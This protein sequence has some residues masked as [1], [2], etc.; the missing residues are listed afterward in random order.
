MQ[1]PLHDLVHSLNPTEKRYF[2]RFSELHSTEGSK[3]YLELFDLLNGQAEYD[4]VALRAGLGPKVND[5]QLAV[6]R[7]YL[8]NQILR[9]MRAYTADHSKRRQIRGLL[10]DGAFLYEKSLL[11]QALK[12]FGKAKALA[13]EMDDLL[14]LEEIGIWERRLSKLLPG[15]QGQ[16]GQGSQSSALQRHAIVMRYYDLYDQVYSLA[17]R[18]FVARDPHA[19]DWVKALMESLEM[20]QPSQAGFHAERFRLQ[21]RAL[22]WQVLGE[23]KQAAEE[24]GLLHDWWERHPQHIEEEQQVFRALLLNLMHFAF[25]EGAYKEYPRIRGRLDS[26]PQGAPI[27]RWVE[28]QS[29]KLYAL[30]YVLNTGE[31]GEALACAEGTGAWLLENGERVRESLQLGLTFNVAVA[32]F[33]GEEFKKARDWME[34]IPQRNADE[35]RQDIVFA[36]PILEVI[37]LVEEGHVDAAEYRLAAL[38]KRLSR[39]GR[40]WPYETKLLASIKKLIM[41]GMDEK[42]K[43]CGVIAGTF[44]GNEKTL[45]AGAREIFLWA[46]ARAQGIPL[47]QGLRGVRENEKSE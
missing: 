33:F 1:D 29:L 41:T 7:G 2:R 16:Q 35:N 11:Q 4:A 17:R 22:G 26:L 9:A 23:R 19:R 25:Q 47:W 6:L 36:A 38:Q 42:G 32:L 8:S 10:L 40:L 15:Q 21:T 20:L 37:C 3:S 18:E 13:E 31:V 30:V 12:V 14:A 34:R 45:P 43:A 24:Y 28:E 39:R 44:E 27:E 5:R 46:Q